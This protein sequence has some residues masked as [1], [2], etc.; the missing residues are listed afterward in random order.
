MDN[1]PEKKFAKVEM[2]ESTFHS[3]NGLEFRDHKVEF[4]PLQ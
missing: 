2:K 3:I 1:D 4:I